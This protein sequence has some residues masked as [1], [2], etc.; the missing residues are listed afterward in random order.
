MRSGGAEISD[1]HAGFIV[2]R[3]GGSAGDY[4]ALKELARETVMR[5]FGVK[6]E[7]EIIVIGNNE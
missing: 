4:L 1:K 6:A 5:K 3:G 7:D 2:N